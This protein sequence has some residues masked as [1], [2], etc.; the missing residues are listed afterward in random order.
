MS[1]RQEF[2]KKKALKQIGEK[3][4]VTK[5]EEIKKNKKPPSLISAYFF[6]LAGSWVFSYFFVKEE[7]ILGIAAGIPF[8]L[9]GSFRTMK[10]YK[11]KARNK[12]LKK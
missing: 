5:D 10:A 2:L 8:I 11:A 3:K 1:K 12:R 7:Y 6:I 9:I 4:I